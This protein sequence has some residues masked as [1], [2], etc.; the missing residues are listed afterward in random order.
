MNC[1]KEHTRSTRKSRQCAEIFLRC[2]LKTAYPLQLVLA[3]YFG[4]GLLRG[5]RRFWVWI[6][7]TIY[8]AIKIILWA[9]TSDW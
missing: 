5:N 6:L 1:G 4:Y 9:P 7:L 3:G 2:I 8:L